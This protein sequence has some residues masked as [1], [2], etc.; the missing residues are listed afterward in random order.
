MREM[1]AG[2]LCEEVKYFITDHNYVA[3][4]ELYSERV[5]ANYNYIILM[6]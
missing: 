1:E 6:T 4:T 2:W 3:I 5:K